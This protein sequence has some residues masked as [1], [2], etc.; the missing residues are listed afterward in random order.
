MRNKHSV[1][2]PFAGTAALCLFVS[3]GLAASAE[4]A[5]LEQVRQLQQENERLRQQLDRQQTLIEDFN[6]RLLVIE[7]TTEQRDDSGRAAT[8]ETKPPDEAPSHLAVPLLPGKVRLS[9]EGGVA[10]FNTGAE[11][12]FPHSEFRVEEAKLFV[13]APV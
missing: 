3:H 1:L 9:G 10:F 13:E 4:P 6:R 5:T 8:A 7:G 2:L 11:G 12:M